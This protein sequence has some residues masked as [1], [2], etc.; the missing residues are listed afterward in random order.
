MLVGVLGGVGDGGQRA[1]TKARAAGRKHG[2]G[3]RVP[4]DIGV[5]ADRHGRLGQPPL[6]LDHQACRYARLYLEDHR[7]ADLGHIGKIASD[8]DPSPRHFLFVRA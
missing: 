8:P 6:L 7:R 5:P 4:V 2:T 3:A 1:V